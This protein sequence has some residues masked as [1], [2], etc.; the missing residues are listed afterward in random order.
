MNREK[1]KIFEE[2]LLKE[3]KEKEDLIKAMKDEK[4]DNSINELS[5]YDNH[6]SDSATELFEVE[7]AMAL[8]AEQERILDQV[9]SALENIHQ[10]NYGHCKNCGAP[11]VEKRLE[12]IPYTNICSKCALEKENIITENTFNQAVNEVVISTSF[13]GRGKEFNTGTDSAYEKLESFNMMENMEE[14]SDYE[15][16]YEDSIE[17]I[18]NQQYKNQLQ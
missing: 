7:K 5:N 4:Q 15:E 16:D 2:K 10:E 13:Q 3:K 11:I 17:K 8:Q 6:P 9:N 18:S 1:I 12:E 14:F